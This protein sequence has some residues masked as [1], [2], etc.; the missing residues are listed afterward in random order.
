MLSFGWGLGYRTTG[1]YRALF[2][3]W[4]D[5]MSSGTKVVKVGLALQPCLLVTDPRCN[6]EL[7]GLDA[8]R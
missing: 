3:Q 7:K 4:P 5:V 1:R 2:L 8:N 6:I